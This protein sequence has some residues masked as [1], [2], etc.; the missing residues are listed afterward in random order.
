MP[1]DD[2]TPR[3]INSIFLS[4]KYYSSDIPCILRCYQ[5]FSTSTPTIA[6]SIVFAAQITTYNNWEINNP[7]LTSYLRSV[8]T[9]RN[10]I[11]LIQ[12]KCISDL[13][14]A[15]CNAL[16]NTNIRSAF[17]ICWSDIL[18]GKKILFSWYSALKVVIVDCCGFDLRFLYL[19]WVQDCLRIYAG[20]E[21]ATD[22]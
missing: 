11:Y 21:A 9:T 1:I 15:F 13:F 7:T 22:V 5:C 6:T 17:D 20:F 16:F 18:H 3:Y 14:P 19:T 12:E 8:D 2:S 10:G 4:P